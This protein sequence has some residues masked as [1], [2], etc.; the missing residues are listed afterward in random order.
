[1]E[2]YTYKFSVETSDLNTQEIQSKGW[3]DYYLKNTF[4][5]VYDMEYSIPK[6]K[7]MELFTKWSKKHYYKKEV[8]IDWRDTIFNLKVIKI[9]KTNWYKITFK[10]KLTSKEAYILGKAFEDS[11]KIH[12]YNVSYKKVVKG[13]HGC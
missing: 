6:R 4:L 1:M 11:W 9:K 10:V 7:R 13:Q 5:T 3:R 2:L 8:E 12:F